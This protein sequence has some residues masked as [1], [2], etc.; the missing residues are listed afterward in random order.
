M[1]F[2]M[3]SI[4]LS[5]LFLVL[6]ACPTGK[7]G[8]EEVDNDADG[9]SVE[10]GDCDDTNPAVH[11]D[12]D[13]V[14]DGADNNCDGLTDDASA[15][16]A[17]TFFADSDGDGYGDTANTVATCEAPS[18]YVEDSTDCDDQAFGSN[19][20]ADE[21]CDEVDNNCD[22]TVDEDT[23]VDALTWYVDGDAD[24]FGDGAAAIAT[25]CS[26]P[27][28]YA[29]TGDDCD[30]AVASTYPGADEYCNG[31]DDDCDGVTDEDDAV[32]AAAWYDDTDGD[33]YG[34]PAQNPVTA[35]A[36]SGDYT[37]DN[38]DDCN[39][40]D[41]AVNPA[42]T[43]LWNGTDDDC[44]GATDE[45]I[46]G[47][48]VMDDFS[49]TGQV[50][51]ESGDSTQV[52][53]VVSNTASVEATTVVGFFYGATPSA[54]WSGGQA[55]T[56]DYVTIPAGQ[57]VEHTVTV[58][59]PSN[60]SDGTHYLGAKVD[61][62]NL[63]FETSGSNNEEDDRIFI[64]AGATTCSDTGDCCF[65]DVMNA[66]TGTATRWEG[67]LASSD[68]IY[69][70]THI[71]DY[72]VYLDAGVTYEIFASS[73]D[74]DTVIDLYEPTATDKC[75][76]A[77]SNDDTNVSTNSR[78]DSH[79]EVTPSSSGVYTIVISGYDETELGD[80]DLV[81]NRG[82]GR[83]CLGDAAEVDSWPWDYD[84]NA[85]ARLSS[86]DASTGGPGGNGYPYDDVEFF[87]ER[88]SGLSYEFEM[89]RDSSYSSYGV[90]G[91][92]YDP[93]LW[94]MDPECNEYT[95]QDDGGSGNFD[96]LISLSGLPYD[97]IWTLVAGT[98]NISSN[99]GSGYGH[100]DLT[101]SR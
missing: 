25:A 62:S 16:D 94:L 13:E 100:Y 28:G 9:F 87:G 74:F 84:T 45:G 98:D 90:N 49:T 95:H 36:A 52:T 27:S 50:E 85:T 51:L 67:T 81:V 88:D 34:D 40:S 60:L 101:V 89:S 76:W 86:S 63:L 44:D 82:D 58:T 4:F 54:G 83:N 17:V 23:A 92:L 21:V 12:A 26:Q 43:E 1:R 73:D 75:S 55:L 7:G 35:C 46:T 91:T 32:D 2:Y 48:L 33:G 41:A 64:V 15:T 97:G 39:D 19:P 5:S 53:A 42:A 10:A 57:S 93:E 6:T 72:E 65:S 78:S 96:H 18:G 70:G 24:G 80:F 37:A 29:A 61:P 14:C 71:D 47:D 3:R 31:A 30:D 20:G 79:L 56:S 11:P 69:G 38:A 59:L 66:D 77:D 68:H 22:G 8:E 99:Y